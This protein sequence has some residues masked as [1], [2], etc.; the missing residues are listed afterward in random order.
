MTKGKENSRRKSLLR[1]KSRVRFSLRKAAK[2]NDKLS[3]S[4]FKSC[5]HIYAQVID[6]KSG[7]VIACA[8]TLDKDLKGSLKS[9][10]DKNAANAVGRLVAKRATDKGVAD[11]YFDRSGYLYHGKIKSLA[12]GAREE[13]LK[14]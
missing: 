9:T 4:V 1:R 2:R 10:S 5:K 8:S 12:E 14:F 13:G 11:V 3:L 6:I 7:N